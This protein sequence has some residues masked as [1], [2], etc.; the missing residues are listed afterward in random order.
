MCCLTR[1]RSCARPRHSTIVP[2]SP[3]P[4]AA[5][6]LLI[7]VLGQISLE[8]AQRWPRPAT[9]AGAAMA[10]LLAVS[11]W[12]AQQPGT[13]YRKETSAAPASWPPPDGGWRPS[14]QA[15]RHR[16]AWEM[17]N[18]PAGQPGPAPTAGGGSE[19]NHRLTV[20]AR[21]ATVLASVSLYLADIEGGLVL[22]RH[23]RA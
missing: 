14:R 21:R 1:S 4:D 22:G 10:L 9:A 15:C 2:P 3:R 16:R 20:T 17:L 8:E 6:G 5:S 13:G 7:A 12:S 18:H 23:R 19:M 11:T